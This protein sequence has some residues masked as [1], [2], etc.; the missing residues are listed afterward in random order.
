MRRD[1]SVGIATGYG[2]DDRGLIPEG[3]KTF[4]FKTSRPAPPS[5]T[6]NVYR[7]LSGRGVKL[8]TH[9]YPVPKLRVADLYPYSFTSSWRGA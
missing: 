5:L 3:S 6:Y 9:P 1:S 7:G 2:L 8:T 4:F